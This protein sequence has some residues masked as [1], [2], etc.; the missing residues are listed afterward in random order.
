[1]MKNISLYLAVALFLMFWSSCKKTKTGLK[2]MD[3]PVATDLARMP[4]QA[5]SPADAAIPEFKEMSAKMR[6]SAQLNGKNQSFNAQM[7]WQRG[8][9]I[10]MSMSL[11]GIEGVRV[12]I[13]K[14]SIRWIDRLNNEYLDK[15]YS[16][17]Q[18]LIKLNIPFEALERVLLG[19]PA[20]LDTTGLKVYH[21]AQAQEWRGSYGVGIETNA[22]F[23]KVNNMLIEYSANDPIL[24]RNL[25]TR[26]GDFRPL[27]NRTFAYDRFMKF[28]QG[29]D[30]VELQV[31]FTDVVI[32]EH[33]SY[34]FDIP[35]KYKRID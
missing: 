22:F 5:I 11:L 17:L 28:E 21:G 8:E 19:L 15:P 9:K 12:L 32:T 27:N 31:K 35:S 7:R 20:L 30:L 34:P 18:E 26:Y 4:V 33:L 29:A 14:D 10:W 25:L 24:K 1:M 13:T 16:H 3:R 6:V 2:E 23:S